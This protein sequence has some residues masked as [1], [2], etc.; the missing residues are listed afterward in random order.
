MSTKIQESSD[1]GMLAESI[2]TVCP[3]CGHEISDNSARCHMWFSTWYCLGCGTTLDSRFISPKV[4]RR[5]R[6]EWPDYEREPYG[7]VHPLACSCGGRG[8]RE[9]AGNVF[10]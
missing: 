2:M 9:W 6:N 1:L 5:C 3:N 10:S 4:V 8:W 7:P